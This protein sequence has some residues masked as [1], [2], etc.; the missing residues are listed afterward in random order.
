[1]LLITAIDGLRHLLGTPLL[2]QLSE[3]VVTVNSAVGFKRSHD[4]VLSPPLNVNG[5]SQ[6]FLRA[7]LADFDHNWILISNAAIQQVGVFQVSIAQ[8][9][10]KL[11]SL[12]LTAKFAF[13]NR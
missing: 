12:P 10:A 13:T 8:L 7:N 5:L 3:V 11:H 2:G 6:G 9:L 4:E 1:M